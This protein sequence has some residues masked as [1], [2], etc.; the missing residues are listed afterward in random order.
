MRQWRANERRR[1]LIQW[2]ED[3]FPLAP[4]SLAI[5]NSQDTWTERLRRCP[6]HRDLSCGAPHSS[7][8]VDDLPACAAA[9]E[10]FSLVQSL[11]VIDYPSRRH[12]QSAHRRV[13]GLSDATA[14]PPLRQGDVVRRVLERL[15]GRD[16][17]LLARGHDG[18]RYHF[19]NTVAAMLC[20][21]QWEALLAR[22]GEHAMLTLLLKH[23][24]A[25]RTLNGCSIQLS[26]AV[27]RLESGRPSE[28]G[29]ARGRKRRPSALSRTMHAGVKRRRAV[30]VS[31]PGRT[32]HLRMPRGGLPGDAA[33]L[34]GFR[35]RLGSHC[36]LLRTQ[37]SCRGAAWLARRCFWGDASSNQGSAGRWRRNTTV[38]VSSATPLILQ[39]LRSARH[40]PIA[41]LLDQN[42]PWRETRS[43]GPRL[44]TPS[45]WCSARA[46]EKFLLRVCRCVLP[47]ELFGSD[48]NRVFFEDAVRAFVRLPNHASHL[49]VTPWAGRFRLNDCNLFGD[50]RTRHRNPTQQ[51]YCRRRILCMLTFLFS[52]LIVPL[53]RENFV[54]LE[55]VRG[56]ASFTFCRKD[57][58]ARFVATACASAVED[59]LLAPIAPDGRKS[60]MPAKMSLQM[61]P[62][63]AGFRAIQSFRSAEDL[64]T[65]R[66]MNAILLHEKTAHAP[67]FG[68]SVACVEHIHERLL[69]FKH[70]WV[71]AGRPPVFAAR[72]DFKNAFDGVPLQRLLYH[73]LP[74]LLSRD[75]YILARYVFRKRRTAPWRR[76]Y[77]VCSPAEMGSFEQVVRERLCRQ[78]GGCSIVDEV[79]AQ[80]VSRREILRWVR[81]H[82]GQ[83][84]MRIPGASCSFIQ[85]RGVPQGSPVSS[86]LCDLMFG[87]F[88]RHCLRPLLQESSCA[89]TS[90]LLLR[91][92]DDVLLLSTDRRRFDDT[93]SRILCGS[94]RF[95]VCVNRGKSQILDRQRTA[96]DDIAWCGLSLCLQSLECTFPPTRVRSVHLDST[97]AASTGRRG[98]RPASMAESAECFGSLL[99]PVLLD[100]RLN[101]RATVLR[102][103]RDCL[104]SALRRIGADT[105]NCPL[106]GGLRR[107]AVMRNFEDVA[108]RV[109]QRLRARG[110]H[111]T[112]RPRDVRATLCREIMTRT[113]R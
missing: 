64:A 24:V 102:N 112:L 88:E 45:P 8:A 40:A 61:V 47:T 46:V 17:Y 93:C 9:R 50:L 43:A 83:N 36:V 98:T 16:E 3:E 100:E 75:N 110:A 39:M 35:G 63:R 30:A 41:A 70:R 89:N 27:P 62:K 106:P 44:R 31:S 107:R 80:V 51:R 23:T 81:A 101:S 58:Y 94:R 2:L 56:S 91:Y 7:S 82:V 76:G 34:D 78:H 13:G 60:R 72:F 37:V 10:F 20:S 28:A 73:E 103:L 67:L 84:V 111:C 74:R 85:R 33:V 19:P 69:A 77:V 42:C 4:T 90:M 86:I 87:Q 104:R 59:G 54:A 32:C 15:E 79:A 55:G 97:P 18:S 29:A 105:A 95:G 109:L 6:L 21:P 38:L 65:A 5:D 22:I 71:R 108:I 12:V 11:I 66:V 49:E 68:A 26:G 53:V 52:E 1:P 113:D 92:V 96:R 14:P 99:S 48:H 57:A 25:M